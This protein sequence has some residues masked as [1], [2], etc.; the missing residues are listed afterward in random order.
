VFLDRD[1]VLNEPVLDSSSG[2]FE[3]P[4]SADAVRLAPGAA[5]AVKT[6]QSHGV[7]L[8]VVS[9]QPGAAKG[10]CTLAQLDAVHREIVRR[11]R[12]AGVEI[13]AWM[14]CYHHPDG[15]DPELTR[16]CDCRKPAPGLVLAAARAL[17]VSNVAASWVIGDSDVDIE[18][19]HRLGCRTILVEDART[20]HRRLRGSSPDHRVATIHEAA[21]IIG[22]TVL[23]GA[24]RG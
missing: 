23:E 2:T 5:N 22:S 9:N 10:R 19:G 6:L 15:V 18:A 17:G 21:I 3:S 1:G 12:E 4:Y 13:A 24:V 20:A 8:G 11:L 14:Y 16:A 7:P